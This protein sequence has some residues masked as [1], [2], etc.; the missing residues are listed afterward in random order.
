MAQV[1]LSYRCRRRG[2]C[3]PPRRR[4]APVLTQHVRGA[5]RIRGAKVGQLPASSCAHALTPL[6]GW[7]AVPK[8]HGWAQ[9][10]RSRLALAHLTAARSRQWRSLH[11][12][13]LPP[14]RRGGG[15]TARRR[16]HAS[17]RTALHSLRTLWAR[18]TRPP[19]T[20]VGPRRSACEPEGSAA[21]T[22]AR[23]WPSVIPQRSSAGRCSGS[24]D[25]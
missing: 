21:R 23:G 10:A 5:P 22:W 24:S 7:C 13:P 3:R 12:R 16:T 1:G 25:V 20:A 4:A 11:R 2:R 15:G 6:T 19:H 18:C 17:H 9:H 14:G 8:A